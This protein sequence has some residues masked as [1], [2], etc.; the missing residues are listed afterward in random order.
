MKKFLIFLSLLIASEIYASGVFL[1]KSVAQN[2]YPIIQVVNQMPRN[3]YCWV[4]FN[5]GTGYFDFY[6]YGNSASQWY[7]EPQGYYEWR[8]Q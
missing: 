3:I 6:V 8:C 4:T 1:N 7:F 5:N 2:G